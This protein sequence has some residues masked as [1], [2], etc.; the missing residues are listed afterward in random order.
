MDSAVAAAVTSHFELNIGQKTNRQAGGE[1]NGQ[2]DGQVD[3]EQI[4][5]GEGG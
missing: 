2:V 5:A 4:R 1:S 3:T